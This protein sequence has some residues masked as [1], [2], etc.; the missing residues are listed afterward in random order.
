M[1]VTVAPPRQSI[2]RLWW[3]HPELSLAAVAAAAWGAV[4]I[5]HVPATSMHSQD[6]VMPSHVGGGAT[7]LGSVTLWVLMATAMML[8]TAL[9]EARSIAL[10]GK[11]KRR[12]RG[13]ALFA[14]GYLAVW[15]AV[16][17]VLLAAVRW[18]GPNITGPL[19][20]S[21][22]MAGAAVW[23]STRRKRLLL[24]ACHRL[25]PIPP[26]GPRA[27]NACVREGFR[28][29]LRCTGSCAPIMV[30]MALAPHTTGMSLML[31]LF[32]LMCAE[33]LS[34][35]GVNRL[36][37]AALALALAAAMVAAAALIA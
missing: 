37:L 7:F 22:A 6:H 31:F 11:W 21:A 13:P 36:P 8:P 28:N 18:I 16:G 19:A 5:L 24:R 4:L 26:D 27:D 20:V 14:L 32:A 29:G 1:T 34:K 35:K 15:S 3:K 2:R 33:K 12:Q 23:E 10:N 9:P 30:P 25:S 17:V